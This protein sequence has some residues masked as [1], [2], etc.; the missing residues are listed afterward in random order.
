MQQAFSW[1]PELPSVPLPNINSGDLL[2]DP[3]NPL[4]TPS[5]Q[6]YPLTPPNDFE[7]TL[8]DSPNLRYQLP[9]WLQV[10]TQ[11]W[12]L[13]MPL[14]AILLL[15]AC[16]RI[17]PSNNW[18]RLIVQGIML[19]LAGRYFMWRTVATL[20][21][22]SWGSTVF[23]LLIYV[24]EAIGLISLLINT[25]QSIWSSGERR[26]KEADQY[27]NDILS[28]KYCPSVDVFIPT[29]NEPEQVV[30]RTAVGCL[31][32]NYPN[33]TIYILDDTRRPHIR[34]LAQ[35]LGCEYI[36]RPDNQHAK[37]GNLNSALPKTSGE[38]ITIMDADFV[39]F[40]NFLT[41]T[42]GFFQQPNVAI[43]QTPQ[44]FYNPDHHARNLGIDHLIHHDLDSFFG[45]SLAN[46][47]VFNSALCCGTSYVV[48]RQA[49][50]DIGGYNTVC[51]AEDSP[52]SIKMLTLGYQ[53]VYLKEKL[54]MGESTRTYVDFV[55][56][57]VRWHHSNY[58]IFQ[59]PKV[60]PIWSSVNWIQKTYFFTLYLGSFQPVFRFVAMLTPLISLIVGVS[61]YIT[62]MPE[63]LYYSL[64]F[65]VLLVGSFAWSSEYYRSFFWNE[66]Y[67]VILCFPTLKSL[68]FAIRQPFGLAFKVTRKGVKAE[69][70]T[71][72]LQHT[73]PLLVGIGLTVVVLFIRLLDH[74]LE[75]WGSSLSSEFGFILFWLTYNLILMSLAVLAAIDQ[76]ERRLSD[77]FLLYTPCRLTPVLADMSGELVVP[78]YFGKS[79]NISESGMQVELQTRKPIDLS[80]PVNVDF[81][82]YGFHINAKIHRSWTEMEKDRSKTYLSLEFQ[83][84]TTE[85]NWRLVE[86]LYTDMTWWTENKRPSSI[87]VAIALL[88]SFF[89]LRSLR[90]SYHR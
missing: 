31:L 64:P 38:F 32:M 42:V 53:I 6:T 52:T 78:E 70:K 34:V 90:A 23:S 56:Q 68:W 58:Q 14:F 49:L 24:V 57:R 3:L 4:P 8:L 21:F 61:P 36:T 5:G 63:V 50:E 7:L 25:L 79:C 48:R 12:D 37:A 9:E 15:N 88:M 76:P 28:G 86:I 74:R 33:K 82:E 75:L 47:D 26:S 17:I 10:P 59:C 69:D 83:Q 65:L 39:P 43:V 20:N 51:L 67:D 45:F 80:Q 71:Y 84:V 66:V 44:S 87:D 2:S 60:L 29:Y 16:L 81:L 41:R 89:N 54:S 40:K 85:Q 62:S 77:R 13:V 27:S 35:E 46:R 11:F 19:L 30:R 73:W 72:N 22:S 55:K 1:F 18:S